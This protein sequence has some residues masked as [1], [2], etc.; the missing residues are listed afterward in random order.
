MIDF[1]CKQFRIDEIIK[2][3]LGLTR[4]DYK[5]LLFFIDN[6]EWLTTHEAA[7]KLN[8]NL[9]TVQRG[10]KRLYE[11]EVLLRSQQNLDNGGYLFIY[12]AK[13]KKVLKNILLRIMKR[14]VERVETGL[15]K[16]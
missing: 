2:C 7:K 5:L 10:V 11:K 4:A 14:W 6:N 12:K 8:L 15:E 16:W 1:A 13:E 9:S 3:G